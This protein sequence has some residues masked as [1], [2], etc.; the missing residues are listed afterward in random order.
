MKNVILILGIAMVIF[1]FSGQ[2]MAF[3]EDGHLIQVV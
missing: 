2:A 1:G 3:F